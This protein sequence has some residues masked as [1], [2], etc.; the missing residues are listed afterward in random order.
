MEKN[1][2]NTDLEKGKKELNYLLKV[3]NGEMSISEMR[4]TLGVEG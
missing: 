1:G 2:K 3:A 4:R